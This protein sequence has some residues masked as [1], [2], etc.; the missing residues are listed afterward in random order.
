MLPYVPLLPSTLIEYIE[1][2]QPFIMGFNSS[3]RSLID[4]VNTIKN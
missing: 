4:E 1:A 3:S 2:P